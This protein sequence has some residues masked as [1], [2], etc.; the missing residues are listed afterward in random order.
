MDNLK[1]YLDL[2]TSIT[3]LL[4][5]IT[6]IVYTKFT[7]KLVTSEFGPKLY[8]YTKILDMPSMWDKSIMADFLPG[9]ETDHEI[10]KGF[11]YQSSDQSWVLHV[12]NSGSLP[13]TKVK[14][15]Y[16]VKLSIN[17]IKDE[18]SLE[19]SPIEYNSVTKTINIDYLP[20][21]EDVFYTILFFDRFPYADL[22]VKALK[23]NEANFINS[24]VH[25]AEYHH[26]E[27]D[28][29]SCPAHLRQMLGLE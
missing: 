20:P 27:F 29:L 15:C 21:N 19:H 18:Y 16:T 7:R 4:L 14:L 25:I 23:C 22:F 11:T 6:T 3:S 2:L 12:K 9:G 1:P 26:P 28:N 5:L 8:V 13:A 10:K 24:R 17:Q